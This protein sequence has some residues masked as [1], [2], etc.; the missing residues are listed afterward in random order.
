MPVPASLHEELGALRAE[1][2]KTSQGGAALPSPG[3]DGPLPVESS[4]SAPQM[5]PDGGFEEQMQELAQALSEY[6]GSAEDFVAERST[7]SHR[8]WP[9][10][11]SASLWDG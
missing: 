7:L 3:A 4:G 1:L 11:R 8:C 9:P 2:R 6:A 10:S 5:A